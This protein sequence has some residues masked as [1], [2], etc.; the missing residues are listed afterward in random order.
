[1]M[2]EGESY[3]LLEPTG[4]GQFAMGQIA[5]TSKMLID[6][7]QLNVQPVQARE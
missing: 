4:P 1:L 7:K 2:W 6:S 3:L 5:S